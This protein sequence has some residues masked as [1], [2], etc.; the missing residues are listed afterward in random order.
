VHIALN[1]RAAAWSWSN[2][3][4]AM[5]WHGVPIGART[6]MLWGSRHPLPD[7]VR[8]CRI[9]VTSN[10]TPARLAE[11]ARYLLERRPVLCAGLPSAVAQLSRYVRATFPDAPPKLVPYAKLGGEQV[12]PFQREE[13][14]AHLGARTVEFYGCTEVGSIAAECPAG[15]MHIFAGQVHLEIFRGDE[16]ARPGELGEIVATSL[17]NR[18]M[19]LVRCRIGDHARLSPDSCPC[20]MPHPILTHLLG[21][22]ADVFVAVDG[23]KVHGSVLG[24]SLRPVLARTAP[25]AIRQVLFEQTDTACWKVLVE[26]DGGF[27]EGLAAQ[28]ADIVRDTFGRSCRVEIQRVVSIPREPSGKFRY[29]RPALVRT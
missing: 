9:F 8:N 14:E 11:A 5:L 19:P 4:R 2:E 3:Y 7:W 22:S 25:R 28:L 10:F 26:D 21:R 15:S 6:L 27:D 13:I 1:P 24:E 16:P 29:Y 20:G 23:R 18:A 17:T 12:Y